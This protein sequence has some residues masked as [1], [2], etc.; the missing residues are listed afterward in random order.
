MVNSESSSVSELEVSARQAKDPKRLLPPHRPP[1]PHP[2]ER[3][4]SATFNQCQ[5]RVKR[6]PMQDTAPR[7]IPRLHLR[8]LALPPLA[9]ALAILLLYLFHLPLLTRLD[10][11]HDWHHRHGLRRPT[12]LPVLV[13]LV[14]R[15]RRVL[16]PPRDALSRCRRSTRSRNARP[17]PVIIVSVELALLVMVAARLVVRVVRALL[18][19]LEQGR[20]G[21]WGGSGRDRGADGCDGRGREGVGEE[22]AGAGEERVGV[23]QAA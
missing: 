20:R 6:L 21:G 22:R 7:S 14:L 8:L 4:G 23:C 1:P 12:A 11:L 17:N 13:V 3:R 10:R 15:S 18:A 16:V 9:R 2:S 19:L 5:K